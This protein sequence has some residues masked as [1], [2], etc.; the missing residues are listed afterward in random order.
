MVD[1]CASPRQSRGT[2]SV[3]DP[4]SVLTTTPLENYRLSED[5]QEV[6]RV[7]QL[8]DGVE[9][10]TS[11]RVPDDHGKRG[12]NHDLYDQLFLRST[13]LPPAPESDRELRVVDLFSGCGGLSLGAQVA[14]RALG[15][16]FKSLMAIDND[17]DI[18]EIYK[19][20]L[21]P[22]RA[23]KCDVETVVDGTLGAG[24]T[25]EEKSLIEGI[26]DIDILLSGPPCQGHSDLNNHTR[27]DD[28]KNVLYTR[29]A[30]FAEL[31]LPTHIIVENV[32]AVI[33]DKGK[34]FKKS[35]DHL[36]DLGY[37]VDDSTVDLSL[38]GVPQKRRRHVLLA[39]REVSV[40]VKSI[41]EAN[42][43]LPPRDLRWS[44]GD[45]VGLESDDDMDKTTSLNEDNVDRVAHLFKTKSH[46]LPD[47]FRPDCHR[48]G[49]TYKSM[50]GRLWWEKPAPTITTGFTSPGQGRYIHPGERRVITP[51]EAARIQFFPDFF[52]FNSVTTRR[53]LQKA[54]GNAAP[55]KL[56]YLFVISL[57]S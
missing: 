54:I 32:P 20:N 42:K 5:G 7:V 40:N 38:L 41:V 11:L 33:H 25:P 8:Q 36:E 26:G 18:L 6:E 50:Y 44:I 55:L 22:E 51:H 49:H 3:N 17:V 10:V 34:N 12:S 14:S 30:R 4:S 56:S 47:E 37:N 31:T 45:L 53:V 1:G 2:F 52:N 24:F 13:E 15:M 48:D 27:R 9:F 43:V 21:E 57:L 19:S 16:G 28:D 46:D 23:I 35:K 39:S 29:V